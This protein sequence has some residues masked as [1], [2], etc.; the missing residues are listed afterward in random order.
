MTIPSK[1]KIKLGDFLHLGI[2]RV[3]MRGDKADLYWGGLLDQPCTIGSQYIY[4]GIESGR[5]SIVNDK[6]DQYKQNLLK[7]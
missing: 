3:E 7:E 4:Q 5:D 6:F 2:V 1:F